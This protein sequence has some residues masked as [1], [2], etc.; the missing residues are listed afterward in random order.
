[1]YGTKVLWDRGLLVQDACIVGEPSDLRVGL[2]ERGG[3]W[4]T[5]TARGTAAH[6]S[7]PDLGVN[8]IASMSRFVLRL[9]EVL[10]DREHPLVGRPSVNAALIDGRQ[11]AE[12]RPR[13]LRARH[14]PPHRPRRD[15]SGGGARAVRSPGRGHRGGAP[16]RRSDVPPRRMDRRRGGR[17]PTRR[18]PDRAARRDRRRARRGRRPTSASPASPT[19]ASTST[20]PHIPTVIVGPGSL[21]VAHTAE[22]VGRSSTTSW[23]PRGSTRGSSSGSWA[24]GRGSWWTDSTSS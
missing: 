4:I 10:P 1:M 24:R 23:R 13:S 14:R 8:A 9:A 11:R 19:R 17:R 3:A 7:Q 5:A 12:R 16:R 18:S 21:S 15:G 6:G 22:R 2:A 20:T